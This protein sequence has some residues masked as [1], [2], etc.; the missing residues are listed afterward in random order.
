MARE[1]FRGRIPAGLLYDKR[2]D[3]WLRAEGGEIVIGATSYGAH[4]AGEIIAFT[5]KQPG[6]E[7]ETGRSLGVVEVA[8]T[9]IAVHAPLTLRVTAR[10]ESAIAAPSLINS[11]PYGE[12]WML[13]AEP[14]RWQA[15]RGELVDR[16]AYVE[17]VLALEPDAEV[18]E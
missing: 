1:Q 3:L 5:P 4:I 7:I 12:G 9:L 11:D 10:N 15:E 8:K 14:L 16:E 17:H 6:R 13:R 18:A 2:N